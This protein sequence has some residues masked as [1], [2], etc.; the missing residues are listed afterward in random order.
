MWAGDRSPT[1]LPQVTSKGMSSLR[2]S[3]LPMAALQAQHSAVHSGRHAAAPAAMRVPVPARHT[4][5]SS[6]CRAKPR[7]RLAF[8]GT[9]CRPFYLA[10]DPHP[11]SRPP[12]PVPAPTGTDSAAPAPGLPEGSTC[13]EVS[14][15]FQHMDVQPERMR[16]C[17][18][19]TRPARRVAPRPRTASASSARA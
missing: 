19:A 5:A 14:T 7:C 18:S 17:G 10:L 4:R 1:A 11:S 3:I 12:S 6:G 13:R 16:N 9:A 2:D 15:H 8:R